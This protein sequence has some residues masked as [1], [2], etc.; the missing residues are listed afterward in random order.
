MP[1]DLHFHLPSTFSLH[2]SDG[3]HIAEARDSIEPAARRQKTVCDMV[4][5]TDLNASASE[6]GMMLIEDI[7][8][9]FC[10]I[11]CAVRRSSISNDSLLTR[12]ESWKNILMRLPF[13]QTDH[14]N[15]G[16]EQHMAMRFYYGFEDHAAPGWQA[17]VFARPKA[18]FFDALMLYHLSSL[19]ICVDIPRIRQLA[20]DLSTDYTAYGDPYKEAFLKREADAKV[21]SGSRNG[22][23]ALSH[24]ASILVLYNNLSGLENK[25]V[26]PVAFIAL[27]MAITVVWTYCKFADHVCPG[28]SQLAATQIGRQTLELTSWCEAGGRDYLQAE[29]ES[30]IENGAATLTLVGAR[31]CR[32]GM[33]NL[34]D[35]FKSCLPDGVSVNLVCLISPVVPP[36]LLLFGWILHANLLQWDVLNSVAPGIFK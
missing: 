34:L 3:L 9:G 4:N 28:C 31:I 32:C 29:R 24:C 27:S 25:L 17:V 19:N 12:L 7:Q 14:L 6:D 5:E 10:A 20:R 35:R 26:D 36:S 21:W 11:K 16:H 33:D 2:N 13:Q 22:R 18:L 8:L 15:H 30:W 23:R 1:E